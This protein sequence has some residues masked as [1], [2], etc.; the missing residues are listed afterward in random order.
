MNRKIKAVADKKNYGNQPSISK[1]FSAESTPISRRR[2]IDETP[3]NIQNVPLKKNPKLHPEATASDSSSN[4]ELTESTIARIK[5]YS[6]RNNVEGPR[7]AE[8]EKYDGVLSE[9]SP[10]HCMVVAP[11]KRSSTLEKESQNC[12]TK[13]VK[14]TP[15]E[16]QYLEFKHNYPDAILLIECGYKYKF[17]DE[18]A[19][20]ASKILNIACFPNHNFMTAIIPVQRM[21]YHV[22]KLVLKGYKVGVIKQTETAA[23]KA[24]SDKKNELFSREL[25]AL[26][27]RTTLI[28]EEF[29]TLEGDSDLDNKEVYDADI[30]SRCLV[31][32]FETSSKDRKGC[33]ISLVGVNP[34]SGDLWY[35][36][37]DDELPLRNRLESCLHQ[38]SPSEILLPSEISKETDSLINGY[39][40]ERSARLEK[41]K[42]NFFEFSSALEKVSRF[43]NQAAVSEESPSKDSIMQKILSLPS[44]IVSCLSAIVEYLSSFKLESIMNNIDMKPLVCEEFMVLT[45]A[46]LKGLEI[47][48]N[49]ISHSEHGSLFWVLNKTFTK[50]GERLLKSWISKP[51]KNIGGIE[52]RLDI[53]SEI[54][55]SETVVYKAVGKLL[56]KLPDLERVLC[57][58]FYQKCSCCDFLKLTEALTKIYMELSSISDK[59]K[60]EIKVPRIKHILSDITRLLS[61]VEKYLLNI[62]PEAAK[63][64]DKT[65]IFRDLSMFPEL[66]RCKDE[67]SNLEDKLNELKP[68]I[69]KTLRLISIKYATVAGQKFLIEVPNSNL[70]RVPKDWI[71]VS[72]TKQVSR[73][74]SPEIIKYCK[75][76]DQQ[77]ELLFM[78]ANEAWCK[79]LNEFGKN[80]YKYKRAI[81]YLAELDCYLSFAQV[82]REEKFCRPHLSETDN[83]I[84]SVVQGRHPVLTKLIEEKQFVANDILMNCANNCVIVTGPNMGGKSTYVRQ[85]ALIALM[86][87]IGCYVPADSATVPIF[88]NIY[89]RMGA[90]DDLI[91]RKSTFMVEMCEASEILC[92]ATSKSFVVLDELGRGTST[93]DGTAVAYSALK[94]L[95][96]DI[97]CLTV[98]VTHYPEILELKQR[99]P[100]KVCT[101]TMAYILKDKNDDSDID[102]VT[103]L[104]NVISGISDKS[105]GINVAALAGIPK[106]ILNEAHEISQIRRLKIDILR[107][108]KH[109]AT[110]IELNKFAN[111]A[112]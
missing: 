60:S 20:I 12:F 68:D 2:K 70:S 65:K 75:Q 62:D 22:K 16:K 10:S 40:Y 6:A 29:Q 89:V 84:F 38:L 34:S 8:I 77:N 11:K 94:H 13:D 50:F 106:H 33:Q 105:Y 86:A 66:E 71:K 28:G 82:S 93:N 53:L 61:D 81:S 45:A 90:D 51:L 43:Y 49:N 76:L 9:K 30:N 14:Y 83:R 69:C 4:Y 97:G 1:F 108:L 31:C 72:A 42:A 73:F 46:T 103:F 67:I 27:T 79:Y 63:T 98:F 37:F 18:D 101:V 111:S 87:H 35:S 100:D 15:L 110:K 44:G 5:S 99:F 57:S 102:S 47:M 19:E 112:S 23:L 107:K 95:I 58:V 91:N 109:L 3:D 85:T 104:F 80:F 36:S 26:Y 54:L 17:F 56:N 48:R 59:I 64:G 32:V 21:F 41:M 55:Y 78:H 74:R 92:C 7:K 96:I 52:E 25:Y 24:A 39:C 88:D